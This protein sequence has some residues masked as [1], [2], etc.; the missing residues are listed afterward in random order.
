MVE[1]AILRVRNEKER[2]LIELRT[3]IVDLATNELNIAIDNAVSV[4]EGVMEEVDGSELNA[5]LY[6][7]Q[8]ADP[9]YCGEKI[10]LR[11]AEVLANRVGL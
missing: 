1:E 8:I 11:H 6:A 10:L 7:M 4:I 2:A 9:S 3:E 5:G